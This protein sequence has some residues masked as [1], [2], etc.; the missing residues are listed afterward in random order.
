MLRKTLTMCYVGDLMSK[1]EIERTPEQA[2]AK[3]KEVFESKKYSTEDKLILIRD[4]SM[5]VPF[6]RNGPKGYA[7]MF[8]SYTKDLLSKRDSRS[9]SV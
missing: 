9:R 3:M 7:Y 6:D 5:S 4:I 1:G 2:I 8:S